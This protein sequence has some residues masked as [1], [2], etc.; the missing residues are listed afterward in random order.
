MNILYYQTQFSI[1]KRIIIIPHLDRLYHMLGNSVMQFPELFQ[2]A[3]VS[4]QI[5][6]ICVTMI[7]KG[8]GG[9]DCKFVVF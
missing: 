9:Y 3:H 2:G 4:I 7:M 1:Q 6:K 5:E 8:G